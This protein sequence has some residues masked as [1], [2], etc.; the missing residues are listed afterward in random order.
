MANLTRG[1]SLD[2]IAVA[3]TPIEQ[4]IS[5]ASVIY[6]GAFV[7]LLTA[8]G[9]AVR[10]GTA[11]T[12][13]VQGVAVSSAP[14]PT[15]SGDY[16]V[17]LATGVFARPL[18]GTHP[19]VI[20]DVG[21]VVYASTDQDVSRD[22]GDGP[23]L[24][25]LL[26]FTTDSTARAVV[27]IDPLVVLDIGTATA[28]LADLASIVNAK[29]ASLIGLE[30]A[31]AFTTAATVEAALAEVYQHIRSATVTKEISFRAGILA[32]GTPMAAF[33]D[34]ASSNPGITLADSKAVGLRWN[35]N[36]SQAPVWTSI[37]LP[38]DIDITANASLE[39]YASKTGATVGDATKFT[40]TAFNNAVG[41]LH[42]ADADYGGD[43]T[44]MTA[45]ATAKTVQKVTL[46]L[47]LANLGV[48]GSPVSIS[49]QP[50]DGTLGTD[51]VI[52][53]GVNL[54]YKRKVKT[55]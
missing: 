49:I 48:A 6:E 21:H 1:R 2:Q 34:N 31:G 12:G 37:T 38:D 50:K 47:A 23:A 53:E 42:D 19:P 36:A 3:R 35:N 55:S 15:S 22:S 27:L 11:A 46:T 7:A 10:G 52:V 43:T 13:V 14:T 30:D 32:A 16:S 17:P 25:V 5:A 33:A 24:G 26:G 18:D 51:D 28:A 40:V 44:A 39:V 20:T 41:A 4:P 29:G 54:V 9:Y 45:A 8:T